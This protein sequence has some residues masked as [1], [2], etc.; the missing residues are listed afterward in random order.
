MLCSQ[1]A[2]FRDWHHITTEAKAIAKLQ[3]F[4]R[5]DDVVDGHVGVKQDRNTSDD[6]ATA[7]AITIGP[8]LRL[9]RAG[10]SQLKHPCRARCGGCASAASNCA[11]TPLPTCSQAHS[12][13]GRGKGQGGHIYLGR[14]FLRAAR[15]RW[16][17]FF[18]S[19]RESPISAS[20]VTGR[21]INLHTLRHG[22]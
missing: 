22:R 17:V 9:Q 1:P 13:P 6:V 18:T 4:E 10:R 20:M 19:C 15:G 21:R 3:A 16:C 7:T 11:V 2:N 8:S 5:G 12:D 14:P